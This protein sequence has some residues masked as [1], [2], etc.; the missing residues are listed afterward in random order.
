MLFNDW[1][2]PAIIGLSPYWRSAAYGSAIVIADALVWE[3]ADAT[4]LTTV[5]HIEDFGQYLLRA[6]IFRVVTDWILDHTAGSGSQDDPTL[7]QLPSPA[8]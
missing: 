4:I 5:S 8:S 1:Q 7:P 6:L 2:P 3:G